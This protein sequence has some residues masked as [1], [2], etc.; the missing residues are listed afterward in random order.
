MQ[1]PIPG[2]VLSL[3]FGLTLRGWKQGHQELVNSDSSG[4]MSSDQP[5]GGAS[6]YG[7]IIKLAG[8]INVEFLSFQFE[9]LCFIGAL[10]HRHIL[11]LNTACHRINVTYCWDSPA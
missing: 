8:D 7:A 1:A 3:R 4:S 11:N 10:E 5:P 9:V 6:E 2:I